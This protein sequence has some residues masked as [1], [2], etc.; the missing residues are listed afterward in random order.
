MKYSPFALLCTVMML[1][2]CGDPAS[3][4]TPGVNPP[5]PGTDPVVPV[6]PTVIDTSTDKYIQVRTDVPIKAFYKDVFMDGGVHLSARTTLPVTDYLGLSLEYL[7]TSDDDSSEDVAAQR[8]VIS[9]SPDDINGRLLYPDGAPRYRLVYVNGG[10]AHTHGESLEKKG[11]EN[12]NK[13]V[14]NGGCY[15][16]SCAGAY[17]AAKGSDTK[18]YDVYLGL[19]PSYATNCHL[20]DTYTGLFVDPESPLLQY[21]DFGG[22]NYVADVYHNGGCYCADKDMVDGTVPLARYDYDKD[23]ADHNNMH[24]KTSIWAYKDPKNPQYGCVIMCGS[25]PEAIKEGEKLDLMA[26]M[27]KYVLERPGMATIKGILH[28]GETRTMDKSAAVEDPEHARI[29]DMQC[30]HYAIW[31]PEGAKNIKITLEPQESYNFKLMLSKDT[32]A[33]PEDAQHTFEGMSGAVTTASFSTLTPGQ[34]YIAVQ[35]TSTVGTKTGTYGTD[36]TST[37]ILNGASYKISASWD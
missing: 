32:F 35:C 26:A 11:R 28:N 21:Y 37:G 2:A 7:I 33:F 19:W 29:G 13:F 14:R 8:K 18:E 9:T 12:F 20:S 36:Y 6:E 3:P 16:G 31:I 23:P 22:D 17:L 34:W 10:N 27:V 1:A 5:G 25:H 15:I 4:D 30:H 24:G